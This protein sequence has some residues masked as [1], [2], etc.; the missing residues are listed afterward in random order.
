MMTKEQCSAVI[1]QFEAR[2]KLD[3][4]ELAKLKETYQS[5]FGVDWDE[6]VHIHGFAW[7]SEP[8]TSVI[9]S[10]QEVKK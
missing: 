1:E 3:Q 10:P 5:M 9:A 6:E 4:Y 7:A 2:I 8:S